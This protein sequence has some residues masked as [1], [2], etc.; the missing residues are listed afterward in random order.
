MVEIIIGVIVFAIAI[1][2]IAYAVIT[3]SKNREKILKNIEDGSCCCTDGSCGTGGE[4]N[5]VEVKD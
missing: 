1:G 2:S 5:E 3:A 4:N